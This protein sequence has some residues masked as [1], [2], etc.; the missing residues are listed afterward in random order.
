MYKPWNISYVARATVDHVAEIFQ[1]LSQQAPLQET[2]YKLPCVT[3]ATSTVSA[4]QMALE[5]P[6]IH[7]RQVRRGSGTTW[8]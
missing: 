4:A 2:N 7:Q 5:E 3:W 1:L 8:P 6:P